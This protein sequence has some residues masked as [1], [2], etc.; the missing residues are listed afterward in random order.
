MEIEDI[1]KKLIGEIS[2]LGCSRRDEDRLNNLR[3]YLTLIEVLL[4]EVAYV[5]TYRD[6]HEHSVK[7]IGMTAYK[8]L[9]E[10]NY[11]RRK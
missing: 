6:S 4:A 1:V 11:G 10:I 8:F 9:E 3:K 2:P 7:E 5:S